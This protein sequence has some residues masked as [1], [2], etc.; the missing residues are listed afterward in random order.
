MAAVASNEPEEESFV[1]QTLR[2]VAFCPSIVVAFFRNWITGSAAH[3]LLARVQRL[4]LG[5]MTV[6]L[7]MFA[8]VSS[9]RAQQDV[10]MRFLDFKSGKPITN[11]KVT[12]TAF[13]GRSGRSSVSEKAVVFRIFRKTDAYGRIIIN[14][15]DVLPKH[16]EIWADLSESV[17]E[18]FTG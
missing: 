16:I 13:N 9:G 11:L 1:A 10:T 8:L 6:T 14:L 5:L 2:A 4:T 15:T 7:T 12:I 17:P 18:F 3:R